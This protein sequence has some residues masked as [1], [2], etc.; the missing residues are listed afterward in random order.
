MQKKDDVK[1]TISV[2]VVSKNREKKLLSCIESIIRNTREPDEIIVVNQGRKINFS[3][4]KRQKIRII[5]QQASNLSIGRNIGILE[6]K[7]D[8]LCFTDDDCLVKEDWIEKI[9]DS[10]NSY[11]ECVGVFGQ[12]FPYES[13]L[14]KDDS[15]PC[16]FTKAKK[17]LIDEPC[18][19][20]ESI[21]YGNNMS[22]KKKIFNKE[23]SFKTWL[24][25]GSIGKSAEDAELSLRLLINKNKLL[26]NPKVVVF[27]NRWL[28]YEQE[29]KQNLSYFC[30]EA[31]CYGYFAFQGH[32]FA[33]SVVRESLKKSFNKIGKR[34][35]LFYQISAVYYKLFGLGIGLLF[36][37]F[38][39]ITNAKKH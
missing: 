36:A 13:Q 39:L 8:I 7:S 37:I 28:N 3:V 1:F 5:N 12:V 29:R 16:T 30:G 38:D 20:M 26:F 22:F 32:D 35:D 33:L 11:P 4:N 23:G 27:H 2:I 34:A 10:F 24:S 14:N 18:P 19:H 9:I 6:S 21:G 17:T 31:A 25:V 15:C